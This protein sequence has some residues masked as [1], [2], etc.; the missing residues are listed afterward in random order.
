MLA[1]PAYHGAIAVV[2]HVHRPW[3][4][5]GLL[6]CWLVVAHV[7][8]GVLVVAQLVRP[9][10]GV[11]PWLQRAWRRWAPRVTAVLFLVAIV[12]GSGLVVDGVWHLLGRRH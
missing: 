12:A 2:A 8:L 1:D 4:R 3:V 6:A 11:G 5:V 7:A 9:S 10:R